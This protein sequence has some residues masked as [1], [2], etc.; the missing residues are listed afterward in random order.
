VF[1]IYCFLSFLIYFI[2][3]WTSFFPSVQK[4]SFLVKIAGSRN[5]EQNRTEQNVPNIQEVSLFVYVSELNS[6]HLYWLSVHVIRT[7]ES[8]RIIQLTL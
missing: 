7:G 4:S 2:D 8:F 5:T 3:T 1:I 6:F